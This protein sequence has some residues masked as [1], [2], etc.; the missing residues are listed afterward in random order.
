MPK[1]SDTDLRRAEFDLNCLENLRHGFVAEEDW[2]W[3]LKA[4]AVIKDARKRVEQIK[5]RLSGC[6]KRGK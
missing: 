3:V 4:D 5:K 1:L 2:D 6:Q